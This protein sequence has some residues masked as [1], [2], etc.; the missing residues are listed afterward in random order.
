MHYTYLCIINFVLNICVSV[1]IHPGK[2]NLLD[3]MF[4]KCCWDLLVMSEV[5]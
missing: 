5:V 1:S 2:G 4:L 3:N